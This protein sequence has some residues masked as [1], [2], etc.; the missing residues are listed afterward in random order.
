[1]RELT[2]T[3]DGKAILRKVLV[4]IVVAGGAPS[5]TDLIFRLADGPA[6]D[7]EF[8]GAPSVTL[9]LR[10]ASA[11]R[12][13]FETHPHIFTVMPQTLESTI[14]PDVTSASGPARFRRALPGAQRQRTAS[15]HEA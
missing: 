10:G 7:C 3:K 9:G 15:R 2:L 14:S 11:V 1:M 12:W 4:P 5:E 8:L 6:F 13:H